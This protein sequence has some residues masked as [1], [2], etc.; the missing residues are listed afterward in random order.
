ME[1]FGRV[2]KVHLGQRAI[3]TERDEP[4]L[5]RRPERHLHFRPAPRHRQ[6][7]IR[8][9]AEFHPPRTLHHLLRLAMIIRK[10]F[11]HK[12]RHHAPHSLERCHDLHELLVPRIEDL[13]EPV[14]RIVAV[15]DHQQHRIHIHFA[16][17]AERIGDRVAPFK[18]E[19]LRIV[20]GISSRPNVEQQRAPSTIFP[21]RH[22]GIVH[23]ILPS[24]PLPDIFCEK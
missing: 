16:L 19:P 22:N 21:P 24:P 9:E 10:S 23:G 3:V 15:L 6:R 2:E 12:H 4:F 20:R 14:H 7:R 13:S 17:S 1:R 18:M 5:V 11:V 8:H